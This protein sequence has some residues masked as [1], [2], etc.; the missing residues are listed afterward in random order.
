MK[1]KILSLLLLFGLIITFALVACAPASSEPV[2]TVTAIAMETDPTVTEL[3]VGGEFSPEGGTIKVTWSDGTSEVLPLTAEGV[4]LSTVNTNKIGN[5]TVT[6]TYGGQKTT[7]KISVNET[8]FKVTFDLNY[9]GAE[10]SVQDVYGGDKAVK[11]ETPTR[12]KYTFY[13]W[14]TDRQCTLPFDFD[15]VIN[16]DMTLYADWK[17][18]GKTYYK[19]TYDLNYYGC[20][21]SAYEKIIAGGEN[22]FIPTENIARNEFSFDGWYLDRALTQK[23]DKNTAVTADTTVYAKWTK[24]KAGTSVYVFEAEETDLTGKVGP[25]LSGTAQEKGM[26]VSGNSTAS[27]NKSVSFLYQNGLAL[28]FYFGCSENVTDATVTVSVAAEMKNIS[29]D[30]NEYQ[31]ILNGTPLTFKD[32]SLADNEEFSD[33]IVISGVT[34]KEGENSIILKTNNTKRPLGD[35][36]TYAATAPMVDCIKITTTAVLIWDATRGLPMAY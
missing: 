24:T 32:V 10:T 17:E 7:F 14:F 6:V 25:G 22:I 1:K 18:E 27:G 12:D 11:P 13:A 8:A 23:A 28:E 36:S 33:A 35:A 5:K 2:K 15:S 26:I 21:P 19:V 30:S 3:Q 31:V 34:L 9:D 29:F 20:V 4:E 16:S